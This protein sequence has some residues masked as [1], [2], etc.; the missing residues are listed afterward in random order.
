MKPRYMKLRYTQKKDGNKIF[1]FLILI[2]VASCATQVT[3]TDRRNNQPAI[4]NIQGQYIYERN[5]LP[6]HGSDGIGAFPGSPDL[7]QVKGFSAEAHSDAE[8]LEHMV[9]VKQ[10]IKSSTGSLLMPPKGGN[11]DL[12]D[13]DI[14][15]VL[16]YMREKFSNK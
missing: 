15:E 10:G 2:L 13:Q 12:T 5:C 4:K 9:Q 16:E 7:T 3:E 8:L 11:P 6:C 1:P 14:R